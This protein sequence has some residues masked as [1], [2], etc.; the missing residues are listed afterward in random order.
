MT[1]RKLG[2]GHP[3]TIGHFPFAAD[4]RMSVDS[5]QRTNEWSLIIQDVRTQDEGVYQCCLTVKDRQ[6]FTNDIRLIVRSQ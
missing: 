5:N 4:T 6:E 2:D 1:W 3:L